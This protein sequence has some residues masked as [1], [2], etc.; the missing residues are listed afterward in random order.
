MAYICGFVNKLENQPILVTQKKRSHPPPS[1]DRVI[2]RCSKN[3]RIDSFGFRLCHWIC[4]LG[5]CLSFVRWSTPL[6][7]S[8]AARNGTN[9]LL[10]MDAA[11]PTELTGLQYNYGIRVAVNSHWPR[12]VKKSA[13][14]RWGGLPVLL[15]EFTRRYRCKRRNCWVS[16]IH[17]WWCVA[18]TDYRSI[19]ILCCQFA[20]YEPTN[21][22][23]LVCRYV[24]TWDTC[25]LN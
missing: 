8:A 21:S 6:R 13:V 16:R 9:G 3:G 2:T 20:Q 12:Q 25:D 10:G 24:C 11:E 7:Y 19:G 18:V 14:N 1:S 23:E 5:F 4:P 22:N 15:V 17:V